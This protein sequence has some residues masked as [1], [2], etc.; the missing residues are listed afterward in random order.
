MPR[1]AKYKEGPFLNVTSQIH[2]YGIGHVEE[3]VP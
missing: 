2:E 3:T 1:R